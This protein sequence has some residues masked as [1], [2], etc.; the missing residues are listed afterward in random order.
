M[1]PPTPTF[2]PLPAPSGSTFDVEGFQQRA[3]ELLADVEGV[4]SVVVALPDGTPIYE[5]NPNE[6]V[7]AASLYKLPIM[8]EVFRQRERGELSFDETVRLYPKF[9]QDTHE[10]DPFDESYTGEDVEIG[11]LVRE[12]VRVS[13]NTAAWA[14]LYRV[15]NGPVNATMQELGLARTEI[16]W[17]PYPESLQDP[18]NRQLATSRADEAWQVTTAA[19]MARLYRLLLEGRAVG[20]EA[21]RQMLDLLAQQSVNDRLPALLPPGTVVAHK[22]GNLPGLVHDVGVVY[23]PAG[24]VII[25]VLT[26]EASRPEAVRITAEL[27][28]SAYDANR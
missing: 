3:G 13:S 10:G 8:V 26:E 9:F 22:T 28:R 2:T 17:Q 21:D 6:P 27:A 12:M 15:G 1:P 5:L 14:L 7:E 23:A 24:P 18:S 11:S 20:P 19:D 4:Y 25:S 16:R